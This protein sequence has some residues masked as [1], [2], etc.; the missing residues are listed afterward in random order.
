MLLSHDH[1]FLFI[2]TR[3]TAS[4][5]IEISLSRAMK[6]PRD[7]ITPSAQEDEWRRARFQVRPRN[8]GEE[9]GTPKFY[10]H[11]GIRDIRARLPAHMDAYFTFA[12]ERNPWDKCVS[13]Y[14]WELQGEPGVGFDEWLMHTHGATLPYNWPLYTIDDKLAVDALYRWEDLP[15]A[16]FLAQLRGEAPENEND[17]VDSKWFDGW[18]PHAKGHCRPKNV[19]YSRLYRN[20]ATR[21][22]VEEKFEKEIRFFRYEFE[23]ETT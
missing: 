18:L 3:K 1:K 8:Y 6:N 9:P 7:I 16:L 12:F 4:T 20:A 17:V 10:N 21:E 5:S 19:H 23:E 22:F 15:H 14:Y 2:K 11:I 13:Q